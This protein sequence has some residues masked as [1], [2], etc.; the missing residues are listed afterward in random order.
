MKIDTSDLGAGDGPRVRA[1][2]TAALGT[3]CALYL[4]LGAAGALAFKDT[5]NVLSKQAQSSDSNLDS[6]LSDPRR[7]DP[8]DA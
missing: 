2:F 1:V 3:T 7:L 6:N 5:T 4:A 8:D